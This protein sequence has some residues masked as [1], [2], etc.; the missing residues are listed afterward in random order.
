[1]RRDRSNQDRRVVQVELTEEGKQLNEAALE[2][3]VDFAQGVLKALS[4][5]E[6]EALIGLFGKISER[7]KA[8]KKRA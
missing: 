2:G 8:E 5:A 1:M 6:Q 3:R 7:I 4:A